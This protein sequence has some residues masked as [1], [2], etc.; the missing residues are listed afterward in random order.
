M[1]GARREDALFDVDMKDVYISHVIVF[2]FSILL[3][4][5]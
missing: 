5:K 3:S 1:R 2:L 4:L